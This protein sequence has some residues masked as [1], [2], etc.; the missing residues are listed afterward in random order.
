M[1]KAK[2]R[3]GPK[4]TD[5]PHMIAIRDRLEKDGYGSFEAAAK[6]VGLSY[7]GLLRIC[8]NGLG[9][10]AWEDTVAKLRD[11]GIYDLVP[12]KGSA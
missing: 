6:K 10:K 2:K 9:A 12:R 1:A 8:R 3:S 4:M 7:D 11:L 5:P